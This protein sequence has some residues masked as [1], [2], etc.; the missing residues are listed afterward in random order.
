MFEKGQRVRVRHNPAMDREY[1]GPARRVRAHYDGQEGEVVSHSDS[2][3]LCFTVKFEEPFEGGFDA[4]YE[5][6]ELMLANGDE[7]NLTRLFVMIAQAVI[8][9]DSGLPIE[10]HSRIHRI[11]KELV[12]LRSA[13]KVICGPGK[14]DKTH[15]PIERAQI[16]GPHWREGQLPRCA[17]FHVI[18]PSNGAIL[19]YCWSREAADGV[20]TALHAIVTALRAEGC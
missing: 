4:T 12:V 9:L 3:G 6:E 8:N 15:A 17:P 1:N 5:T 16:T 2:H 10:P 20:V 7:E 14:H 19:A 13:G 18:H 11:L